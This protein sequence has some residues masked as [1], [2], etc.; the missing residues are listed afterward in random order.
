MFDLMVEQYQLSR[1]QALAL[2]S[3]IVDLRITKSPTA[4]TA[5]TLLS[6]AHNALNGL[7]SEK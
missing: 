1:P 6:P 5:Y 7:T 4:Y 2:A 3:L